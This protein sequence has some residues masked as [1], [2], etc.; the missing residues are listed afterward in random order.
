[1]P[2]INICTAFKGTDKEFSGFLKEIAKRYNTS[3]SKLRKYLNEL[4]NI[5][6]VVSKI[7]EENKIENKRNKYNQENHTVLGFTGTRNDVY[8][9]FNLN[10]SNV[11]I[12]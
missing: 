11:Q 8:K 6:L 3:A 10:R 12:E 9:H 2:K 5:D 1:M 7:I 4:N